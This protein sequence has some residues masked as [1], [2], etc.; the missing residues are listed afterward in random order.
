MPS[1]IKGVFCLEGEYSGSLKRPSTVG[2]LLQLVGGYTRRVPY[3]HRFVVTT[4]ELG[5]YLDRWVQRRYD[6]H[7]I[8][9]LTCHGV[10]GTLFFRFS[11]RG[12]GVPLDWLEERLEGR[13]KG[14][15]VCVSSCG[16]LDVG[17][18]RLR[19]FVDA[20]G[21]L[22]LCGYRGD[23]DWVHSAALDLVLLAALQENAATV[24]GM[25]AVERKVRAA[26]G[27]L[28]RRQG[29]QMVVRDGRRRSSAG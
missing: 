22:A 27:S 26:A 4:A 9:Y 13:C 7:P 25:R 28:V 14:R 5:I 19:R 3:I 18:R 11:G 6:D 2:P 16:T 23:V 8:L 21:A 29:F 17:A 10:P 15:I 12:S 24:N 1:T 20:T